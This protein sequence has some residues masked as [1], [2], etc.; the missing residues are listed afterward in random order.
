LDQTAAVVLFERRQVR[1]LPPVRLVVREH[2]AVHVRCPT[3]EQVSVGSF[4]AEASSRAQYRPRVRA[5]GVNL[6]EQ[7]LVPYA[8]VREL[9][10]EVVG[11]PVSLGTLVR[12]VRQG[13]ETL[14]PVEEA[15]KAALVRAPVLRA[16]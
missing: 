3:C 16:P 2:R 11:A 14:Q 15:I 10:A 5:L 8:R 13:A 12:W 6:L 1:D 9:C 4:P 7:Q